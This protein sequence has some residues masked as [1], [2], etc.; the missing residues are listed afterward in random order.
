M[1]FLLGKDKW[2][3]YNVKV[4][5]ILQ[6][7][8]ESVSSEV[9]YFTAL[10]GLE[11]MLATNKINLSPFRDN[12]TADG[13]LRGK[14]KM[15]FLSTS[16]VKFG[17][18]SMSK[19]YDKHISA[20]LVLNG[21]ALNEKHSSKSVDYWGKA[22]RNP[23]QPD[24]SANSRNRRKHIEMHNNENEDRIFSDEPNLTPLKKYVNSINV[25]CPNY[26]N[27]NRND[28]EFKLYGT[29]TK[30][31]ER[32]KQ[33][34]VEFLIYDNPL[35]FKTLR[36]GKKED[37]GD[38]ST[39]ISDFTKMAKTGVYNSNNK[40]FRDIKEYEYSLHYGDT[41]E[42]AALRLKDLIGTLSNSMGGK[43]E[44]DRIPLE[45]F[46]STMRQFKCRNIKDFVIKVADKVIANETK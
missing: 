31:A 9:F 19:F 28:E 36:K 29:V 42:R 24:D 11:G 7:I 22:M 21:A 37:V 18:Y 6:T 13:A 8:E 39:T 45:E 46:I 4:F 43:D 5:E 33:L 41:K 34:G 14:Q 30:L 23:E 27:E 1:G 38:Y 15:Y 35:Y 20:T 44:N 26:F 25:F 40:N 32:A 17:G 12:N 16:R 3:D 2:E 10:R